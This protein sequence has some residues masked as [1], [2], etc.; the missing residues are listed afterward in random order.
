MRG[1]RARATRPLSGQQDRGHSQTQTNEVNFPDDITDC[2]HWQA[3]VPGDD[4]HF[5]YQSLAAMADPRKFDPAPSLKYLGLPPD[6]IPSPRAEPIAFLQKHLSQLPPH[7]LPAY[8]LITSPKQ[9]TVIPLVR[10]RRLQFTKTAPPELSFVRARNTWP[11]LW[12]GRLQPGIEERQEEQNWVEKHFMDGTETKI[13]K[14]GRLLADFE[15][16][17]ENERVRV[18]RRIKES[19]DLVPEEDEDS[20]EEE[21]DEEEEED[22]ENPPESDHETDAEKQADFER[23]IRER[24]VYGL[25]DVSLSPY[26]IPEALRSRLVLRFRTST[27]TR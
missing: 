18:V 25:L 23:R 13:G 8:S 24:F 11:H 15:E 10:N 6:Y 22:E 12:E 21:G 19:N 4:D 3:P 1:W 27:M 20:D 2:G 14:L 16:E 9:R 7:L 26:N 5:Q 17:R